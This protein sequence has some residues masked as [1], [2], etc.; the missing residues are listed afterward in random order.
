MGNRLR[1]LLNQIYDGQRAEA[2]AERIEARL[3]RTQRPTRRTARWRPSDVALITYADAFRADGQ[4]ALSCLRQ[5]LRTWL[6]GLVQQVHLLPFFPYTSDDGFAVSDYRAVDAPHGTWDD[7]DALSQDCELVFDLVINHASSAHG[8]F[9]DFLADRAPGNAYF[10][11]APKGTDVSQVTRPR[12]SDLLQ[13]YETTSGPKQV[14]CTFS[15]DQVDWDFQNPDVLAEFVDIFVT[16]I[17]RGATWVRLD[18]IAYLWKELGTD[19]VHLPQTHAVVKL[20][21]WIA[22]TLSTDLKILTETNVPLAENL[23]YF[24]DGDEAH[25]VYNFSLPPLLTHALV[26]GCGRHLTAWCQSLPTLPSGCT[27]LNFTASHDGIGLRPA[28]GILD[29]AELGQLVDCVQRFGGLLTQRRRSDG[30]LSPYEANISLFA[31]CK[32]TV[33]GEDDWQVERFLV[34]QGVM[35]AMAGVPALYYNSV[36]AAPNYVEGFAETGRNRTLNRRKWTLDEVSERFDDPHGAPRQVLAGLSQMIEV[37]RAQPAFHPEASQTCLTIDE[38]LFVLRR[39]STTEG[40]TILC[41]FNLTA[42]SIR[43]PSEGLGIGPVET[44]D[45]LYSRGT[46]THDENAMMLSPYAIHWR[47]LPPG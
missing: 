36:L 30:S 4:P 2:L 19:C 40:Q 22:E 8:L 7:V 27:Y 47:V 26:T 14:W 25:I 46:V 5:F 10:L 42:D 3:A 21:R 44:S 23:S 33:E 39:Q 11:T 35:L 38:G 15:R 1:S 43:V 24:G 6:P 17:E 18:A 31:A 45:M 37:R 34:S 29:D 13:E 41:L 28:E 20:L 12:A 16:Y 9:A 32:G